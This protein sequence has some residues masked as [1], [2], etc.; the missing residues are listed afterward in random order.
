MKHSTYGVALGDQARPTRSQL[1]KMFGAD[2]TSDEDVGRKA[3]CCSPCIDYREC[4]E[5][6]Q[7]KL[8]LSTLTKIAPDP[9]DASGVTPSDGADHG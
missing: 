7:C 6:M 4:V 3:G 9:E 8:N 2:Y 1:L 5:G